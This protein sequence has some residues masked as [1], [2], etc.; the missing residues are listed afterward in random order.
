MKVLT[1]TNSGLNIH[2]DTCSVSVHRTNIVL[3]LMQGNLS[4]TD[5][6]LKT[7]TKINTGKGLKTHTAYQ[8]GEK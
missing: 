5:T 4:L 8:Y 2:A 7:L 1:D 6:F 3:I